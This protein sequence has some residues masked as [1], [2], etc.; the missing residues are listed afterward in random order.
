MKEIPVFW[1]ETVSCD[2]YDMLIGSW[3]YLSNL[4]AFTSVHDCSVCLL[5]ERL[6]GGDHGVWRPLNGLH[7]LDLGE[8][9][10]QGQERHQREGGVHLQEQDSLS[11]SSFFL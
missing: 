10:H 9:D 5:L 2:H 8:G 4:N 1:H 6:E 7:H 11:S 3:S